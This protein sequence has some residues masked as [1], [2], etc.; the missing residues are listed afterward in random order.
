MSL[1]N[2]VYSVHTYNTYRQNI[3]ITVNYTNFRQLHT[4]RTKCDALTAEFKSVFDTKTLG[5]LKGPVTLRTDDA[6]RPVKCPPRRVPIAMQAKLRYELDGL[7]NLEIIILV[8]KPT[9]WCPQISCRR[10]RVEDFA[11]VLTPDI[12]TKYCN[13]KHIHSYHR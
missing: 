7:V 12:L 3:R 4:I 10:R 9:D 11:F 2:L 6:T 5:C 1:T 13:G 8:S